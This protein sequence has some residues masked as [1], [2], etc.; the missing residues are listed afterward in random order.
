MVATLMKAEFP[1][2]NVRLLQRGICHEEHGQC[3]NVH[4]IP[5]K[6]A[7]H[8]TQISYI[9]YINTGE[10]NREKHVEN[11][12]IQQL[13]KGSSSINVL[14]SNLKIWFVLP[15]YQTLILKTQPD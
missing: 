10:T 11:I 13:A 12:F 3:H 15:K 1:I 5:W 4:P 2:Q 9:Y 7:N 14:R 8:V 6:Y